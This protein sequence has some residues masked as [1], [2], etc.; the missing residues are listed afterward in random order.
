M[1]FSFLSF[2]RPEYVGIYISTGTFRTRGTMMPP[3]GAVILYFYF[4]KLGGWQD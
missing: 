2:Y 4:I 1:A 3:K